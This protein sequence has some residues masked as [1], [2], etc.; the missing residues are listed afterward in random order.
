MNKLIYVLSLLFLYSC[1]NV[2][3]TNEDQSSNN[4]NYERNLES[5]KR[6]MNLHEVEDLESQVAMLSDDLIHEPPRYGAELQDKQ[7][8]IND[9]VSYQENF[10]NMNFT[11]TYWLP[12][13][14]SLGNLN[15]SVRVYGVWTATHTPTQ[16]SINLK[17]YHYWDFNDD[18]LI[19]QVG[20]YFDATG[21]MMS[22][23][24]E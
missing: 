19:T 23:S 24:E 11:P 12:G 1:N 10:E 3:N 4:S 18:G 15:G 6:F 13:S 16:K 20:D 7:G 8:F 21:M 17:S 22:L 2:N 5:A 9:I 14:D